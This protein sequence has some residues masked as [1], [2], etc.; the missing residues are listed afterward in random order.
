[1][2]HGR[3]KFPRSDP[4]RRQQMSLV[5]P[6]VFGDK[7]TPPHSLLRPHTT[8]SG[9]PAALLLPFYGDV[10][11]PSA[12]IHIKTP[13]FELPPDASHY[14]NVLNGR[15][16]GVLG[17]WQCPRGKTPSPNFRKDHPPGKSSRNEPVPVGHPIEAIKNIAEALRM[18]LIAKGR[19]WPSAK[20]ILRTSSDFRTPM[21]NIC[22][23]GGLDKVPSTIEGKRSLARRQRLFP[24]RRSKQHV[25]SV[26]SDK[27]QFVAE[28]GRRPGAPP[29]TFLSDE[30]SGFALGRLS[31]GGSLN[32]VP[33]KRE[34]KRPPDLQLCD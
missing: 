32:V 28:F 22:V 13:K 26:P 31:L 14:K 33:P 21:Q 1:M 6:D 19:S 11:R 27:N 9:R 20:A 34:R 23:H 29:T 7:H 12:R 25:L 30:P 5:A 10:F 18:G 17:K 3:G 2:S 8:S 16:T 24:E 4:S 15:P